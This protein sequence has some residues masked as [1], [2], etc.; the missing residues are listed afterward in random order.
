MEIVIAAHPRSDYKKNNL[1]SKKRK[2][3]IN[4]TP[5]L[6]K[7]S[8]IVFTHTSQSLNLLKYSHLELEKGALN[9]T[10]TNPSPGIF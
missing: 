6:V 10:T 3:F 1:L 9:S 5:E 2:F 4:K 7:N 8:K